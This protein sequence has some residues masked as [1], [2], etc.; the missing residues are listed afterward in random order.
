MLQKQM[1]QG[2]TRLGKLCSAQEKTMKHLF[3]NLS[4]IKMISDRLGT[5]R[6]QGAE[7][8]NIKFKQFKIK[9]C[10]SKVGK[11]LGFLSYMM[12]CIIKRFIK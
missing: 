1:G 5:K 2:N 3:Q 11:N 7:F 10:S 9:I 8:L 4:V 12:H 6:T